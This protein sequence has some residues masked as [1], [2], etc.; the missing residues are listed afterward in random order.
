[1]HRF[2][3]CA[4]QATSLSPWVVTMDALDPF[5]CS[6]PPQ[7]PVVLSYLRELNRKTYDIK[8]E[9]DIKPSGSPEAATITKSNFKHLYVN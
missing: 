1:M 7:D 2:T 4:L 8:L 5:V 9:V 3:S 6:A